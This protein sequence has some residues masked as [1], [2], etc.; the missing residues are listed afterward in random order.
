MIQQ[1]RNKTANGLIMNKIR[2]TPVHQNLRLCRKIFL[3][4]P[5]NQ[6]KVHLWKCLKFIPRIAAV[7]LRAA[8]L[9][10]G[11]SKFFQFSGIFPSK[12]IQQRIDGR[13]AG[14]HTIY[15]L[16]WHPASGNHRHVLCIIWEMID[17]HGFI[18]IQ[19]IAPCLI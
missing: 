4:F 17:S 13:S 18:K 16:A 19:L 8:C 12:G 15:C 6:A 3:R 1:I 14:Y 7:Q 2:H 11:R 10:A 9:F 5:K